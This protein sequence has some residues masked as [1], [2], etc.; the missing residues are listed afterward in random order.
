MSDALRVLVA[1]DSAGFRQGLAALL[2][3]VDG[4]ELVGE[5]ID[6]D[7]AVAARARAATRR[8]ADGPATCR[9]ATGSRRPREIVAAAPHIAVLVLTMHEDDESV[10]S[11]VQAGARG[12]LVKGA[13]QAE[14]LRALRTVADGGAVF[15]PAIARR[16]VG[17][18]EAAASATR[19]SA[20]P[21]PDRARA[22]DPRPGRP[23][24][25]ERADRRAARPVDQDGAQPRL[26]RLHEDA[27]RRSR[28]GDRQGARGGDR[29]A[30]DATPVAIARREPAARRRTAAPRL[31]ASP[32]SL[33]C[34]H[35]ARCWRGVCSPLLV[36]R[37]DVPRARTPRHRHGDPLA[38]MAPLLP[39][40]AL[41]LARLPRN[42][43][44]W[45][46]CGTALGV[47]ARGRRPGVRDL[48]ALRRPLPGRDRGSAGS[49]SGRRR[50][51]LA[52][53][54]VAP[55]AVPDRAAAVASL[56]PG[57]LVRHRRRLCS[58]RS[59]ALL[60]PGEDLAFLGNPFSTGT[61][62]ASVE[63]RRRDRLVPDA[64]RGRSPAS[65][66]SSSA[67]AP[68]TGRRASSSAC[69][70]AAAVV[71]AVGL[72]C[73]PRSAASLA[74][75]AFDVGAA[76]ACSRS[77][78]SA[79]T[80]AVAIL[81]YRLYGLDVYVNRALVYTGLTPCPRRR[82]TSPR[83]SA[84]PAARP[85]RRASGSRCPRRRSWRSRST[86]CATGCSGA[87]TA[88]CTASA[89]S[90]TRRSRRSAAVSARRS[91]PTD[92]LPVMVDDDRRRAAAAV[93]R[94]R[95]RR[96]RRAAGRRARQPAAGIAL[97]LPLVHG[98][99]RVGTLV[100]G[101]RAHGEPLGD[102][103]PPAA[104]GLR[105]SR[106]RG[107]QRGR[108]LDRGAALARAAG[109]RTRGG[110]AAAARRPARRSRADARRRG[111]HDRRGPAGTR[112]AIPRRRMRCST[113]RREP[114]RAPSPTCAGSS[115]ACG[116]RRSTSSGSSARCASRRHALDV[117]RARLTARSRARS[118]AA[119]C[120]PPSRSPRSGSRRRR[121]RTSRGTRTRAT[122][123]VSLTVDDALHLEIED[124]GRGL[125]ADRPAGVGLTSMRERAAE[126][127]GTLDIRSSAAEGTLVTARIPLSSMPAVAG[128]P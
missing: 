100:V 44:G 24:L 107:G 61:S 9:G 74:P 12:Y 43:I 29:Q 52:L 59:A 16:M 66:R 119:R 81:R 57:A 83:S 126:L 68:P 25:V 113:R 40:G 118:A 110:A 76:P 92:V 28:A 112:R 69:C 4:I 122:L 47:G 13:R 36:A 10:F 55:A 39:L 32:R 38:A 18:F 88:C 117:R 34:G 103:R 62:C 54:T 125:R 53:V 35:G 99:E 26:E 22:R 56:A 87:S 8:R 45:I 63:R 20:V 82:C 17:F 14:L 116:R 106:R 121:S 95:A 94:G 90:P 109:H 19:R 1:D 127:G 7:E 30:D 73:V 58:S 120:R 80:M 91:A 111:P 84:R 23:R 15:G 79:G 93:R 50:P 41:M 85:G 51:M 77:R 78:S 42:P 48:L 101:A 89:T 65:P 115:T 46:L 102:G 128:G 96:T 21:R 124:D 5:A 60:G 31:R 11:A 64:A 114:S 27:G 33:G 67:A 70:G 123:P 98:G 72:R 3:S 71:V 75:S 97:R 49:A 105:P 6:G 108:A 37:D 104:R 86:R 2:A